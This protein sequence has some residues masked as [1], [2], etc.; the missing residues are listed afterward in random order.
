MSPGI[1]CYAKD[2]YTLV[3][4]PRSGRESVPWIDA[5]ESTEV[6]APCSVDLV[7]EGGGAV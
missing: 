2:Y 4:T 5:Y 6:D 1:S 7:G 3:F